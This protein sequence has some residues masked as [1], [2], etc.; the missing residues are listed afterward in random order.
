MYNVTQNST[1]SQNRI[2]FF[3]QIL[4][5]EVTLC[6]AVLPFTSKLFASAPYFINNSMISSLS[7]K[8]F[9]Q[10]LAFVLIE[11]RIN[12]MTPRILAAKLRTGLPSSYNIFGL[13]V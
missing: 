10:T 13:T 6:N 9:I 5:K 12:S 4:P 8:I 7:E 2:E 1:L 11:K 3:I